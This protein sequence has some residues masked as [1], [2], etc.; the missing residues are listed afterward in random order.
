MTL[1]KLK[2]KVKS[3]IKSC[4][5]PAQLEIARNYGLLALQQ[6][7][8]ELHNTLDVTSAKKKYTYYEVYFE[9]EYFDQKEKVY[10]H[11]VD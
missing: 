9:E 8:I 10:A 7:R 4:N 11:L 6:I 5:T 1:V 3:V 2:H